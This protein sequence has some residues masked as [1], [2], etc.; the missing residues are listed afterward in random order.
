MIDDHRT[1]RVAHESDD[2]QIG[3]WRVV[4]SAWAFVLLSFCCCSP[5]S[6]AVGVPSAPTTIRSRHLAAAVIPAA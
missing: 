2:R 6:S 1:R 3:G 5:G 4:V